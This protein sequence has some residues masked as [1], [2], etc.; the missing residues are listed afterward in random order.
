MWRLLRWL[1]TPCPKGYYPVLWNVQISWVR[2]GLLLTNWGTLVCTSILI[3]N[4][5]LTKHC[6]YCHRQIRAHMHTKKETPIQQELI[7]RGGILQ[8]FLTQK[9]VTSRWVNCVKAKDPKHSDKCRRQPLEMVYSDLCGPIQVPCRKNKCILTFVNDYSRYC[10]MFLLK[11]KRKIHDILK[12][13]VAIVSKQI[14]KEASRTLVHL[15][16][17]R[18]ILRR[19]NRSKVMLW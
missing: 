17:N 19:V 8:Q 1:C 3:L 11:D 12:N 4:P 7:C 2:H 16:Q 18:D 6:S 14:W 10:M 9:L 15:N 13:Y 5:I